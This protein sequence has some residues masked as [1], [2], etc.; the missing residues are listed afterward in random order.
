MGSG[1]AHRVENSWKWVWPSLGV[2]VHFT[3]SALP[4]LSPLVASHWNCSFHP[5]S[6]P[7]SSLLL[8]P[9]I[10]FKTSSHAIF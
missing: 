10:S 3:C 1:C 2:T 7:P 8:L 5:D 4:A 6:P 9:L